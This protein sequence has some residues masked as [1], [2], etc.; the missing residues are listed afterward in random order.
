MTITFRKKR[1][2]QTLIK[3]KTKYIDNPIGTVNL[4]Q[5]QLNSLAEKIAKKLGGIT[6]QTV[7]PIQTKFPPKLPP[8][9]YLPPQRPNLPRD[10]GIEMHLEAKTETSEGI[11][12]KVEELGSILKSQ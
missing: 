11:E 7:Q 3:T 5:D 1:I 4:S 2:G 12:S 10:T 9:A 8:R 6:S